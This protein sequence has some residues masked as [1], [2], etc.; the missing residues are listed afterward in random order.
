MVEERK[1]EREGERERERRRMRYEDVVR[2]IK[3]LLERRKLRARDL[4]HTIVE[5]HG[6]N[7]M[8]I[9]GFSDLLR[10]HLQLELVSI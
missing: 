9:R 1:T 7:E 10:L 8:T 2:M 4:F 3:T 6:E 5:G